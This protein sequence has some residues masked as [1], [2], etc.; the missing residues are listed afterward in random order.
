MRHAMPC[1]T[2]PTS[3]QQAFWFLQN[4][5]N[6]YKVSVDAT[7]CHLLPHAVNA[8]PGHS[9]ILK[10]YSKPLGSA[11]HLNSNLWLGCFWIFHLDL[12]VVHTVRP[13]SATVGQATRDSPLETFGKGFGKRFKTAI[14]GYCK[15][16]NAVTWA[17]PKKNHHQM[18]CLKT[19]PCQVALPWLVQCWE[20]AH[21]YP[22]KIVR[23][24]WSELCMYSS[25][26]YFKGKQKRRKMVLN[27][28]ERFND[29]VAMLPRWT[30]RPCK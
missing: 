25:F 12:P 10:I 17:P 11:K 4:N 9:N 16:D 28:L 22:A 18:E 1:E 21:Q 3:K 27:S 13:A 2:A 20:V 19:Q 26:N 23:R 24:M 30:V 15:R 29:C 6:P 5:L 7:Y 8:G 14:D